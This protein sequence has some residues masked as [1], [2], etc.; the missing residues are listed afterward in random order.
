MA[1][2]KLIFDANYKQEKKWMNVLIISMLLASN[3]MSA[4]TAW[5]TKHIINPRQQQM[6]LYA[7]V[8]SQRNKYYKAVVIYDSM[9]ATSGSSFSLFLFISAPT[10]FNLQFFTHFSLSNPCDSKLA[11]NKVFSDWFRQNRKSS[12]ARCE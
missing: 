5:L 8:N 2:W 3:R 7:L 1:C 9:Y 11:K 4:R 6:I 10:F 12:F